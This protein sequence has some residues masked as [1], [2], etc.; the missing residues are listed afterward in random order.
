MKAVRMKMAVK[1]SI[2]HHDYLFPQCTRFYTYKMKTLQ[3][4]SYFGE[5]K[6][7][8]YLSAFSDPDHHLGAA[9]A[10]AH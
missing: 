3:G 7:T 4:Q 2:G 8:L 5:K 10:Q 1:W 6:L 9:P